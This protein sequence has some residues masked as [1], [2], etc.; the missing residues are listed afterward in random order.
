MNIVTI[1]SLISIIVQSGVIGFMLGLYFTSRFD[2]K[3]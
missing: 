2:E 1:A 3:L